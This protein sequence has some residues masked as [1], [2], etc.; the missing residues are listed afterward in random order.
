MPEFHAD[1]S[2]THGAK[3]VRLRPN[4]QV[5]VVLGNDKAVKIDQQMSVGSRGWTYPPAFGDRRFRVNRPERAAMFTGKLP[6]TKGD[7]GPWGHYELS[8]RLLDDGLIRLRSSYSLPKGEHKVSYDHILLAVPF[9]LVAGRSMSADGQRVKFSAADA[10]L[11][12]QS[13]Y[14]FPHRNIHVLE[15][16]S[17]E[18]DRHLKIGIEKGRGVFVREQRS[19]NQYGDQCAIVGIGSVER[20]IAFTLDIRRASP[21][22]LKRSGDYFEGIDFY[23][24]DQLHIPRY[25][26]CRNLVQ[27]PSFEAGLRYWRY[28]TT[29]MPPE[30]FVEPYV[31][32]PSVARSGR[33]SCRF[34]V[35]KGL[36]LRGLATFAI[37]TE[38]GKPYTFSFYAKAQ[39]PGLRLNV[40]VTTAL[41]GVFPKSKTFNIATEWQRHT[42]AVVAPNN[43]LT[44]RFHAL[45]GKQDKD[46][47]ILWVDDVQ[48]E[49]GE[50][51]EYVQKPVLLN[52]VTNRR[53]NL[54]E[55][56][57]IIAARLVVKAAP[58]AKGQ[59]H[60]KIEDFEY[61]PVWQDTVE[62][63]C[64]PTGEAD[65][66]LPLDGRLP[67]GIFYVN[68]AVV[69]ADGFA[70]HDFFRITIMDFLE[71]RH[72]HHTICG[73]GF[74]PGPDQQRHLQRL[75][76]IGMG[77]AYDRPRS[78]AWYDDLAAQGIEPAYTNLF[79][80]KRVGK[81]KLTDLKRVAD[82]TPEVEKAIRDH[83]R[84]LVTEYPYLKRWKLID[85]PPSTM[86][87]A[88]LVKVAEIAYKAVKEVNPEALVMTHTPCNMAATAGIRDVDRFLAAGGI[89]YIDFVGINCYRNQPDNPDMDAD[90]ATFLAMLDKHGY[91]GEIN[92]CGSY[93]QNYNLPAYGLDV[94][95]GCSSDHFRTGPFSYHAGWGERM[96]AAYTARSWLI[97]YKYG[98]RVRTFIDWAYDTRY[99]LD[100]DMTPYAVSMAP[101]TLG[102]LLGNADFVEDVTFDGQIRCYLFRDEHDRPVAAMW[103]MIEAVARRKQA[104][105]VLSA[106]G[107]SAGIEVFSLMGAARAGVEGD[108]LQV[109][110]TPYPVFLRGA[111][112]TL[113]KMRDT[114]SNAKV[115]GIKP[116]IVQV[117]TK[118]V[119]KTVEV[120]FRNAL[121]R[122]VV[123]TADVIL[124]GR[125][126]FHEALK[127][128]PKAEHRFEVSIAERVRT[129]VFSDVPLK[130]AFTPKGEESIEMDAGFKVVGAKRAR[131][132]IRADGD[133]SDWEGLPVIDL[134]AVFY[135]GDVPIRLRSK[136]PER[137]AWKGPSDLSARMRLAWDR[138]RLY[139]AFTVS[140]DVFA[141]YKEKGP[142]SWKGD[143]LQL[144]FDTWCDARSKPE[145]GFDYNDYNYDICPGSDGSCVAYR[146]VA[147]EQQLAFLKPNQI[148]RAVECACK[149]E[150]GRT[151][152]EVAFPKRQLQPLRLEP[153]AAFGFAAYIPDHDNDYLKRGLTLTLVPQTSPYMRPHLW[154]VLVLVE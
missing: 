64:K 99:L 138:D 51:T 123:G 39:Q 102:V 56:G 44:V 49:K 60:I 78:K 101:N 25:G 87:V 16:F 30:K 139:L 106:S 35:E 5:I 20:E 114:L 150:G 29:W 43:A 4:G 70:D 73:S 119:G 11:T 27:N 86:D 127:L 135:E 122:P 104:P 75:R 33:Q 148:E 144:Y 83:C 38:A 97:G 112:G 61:A 18:P 103:P 54:F 151:I 153:G 79:P 121:S 149:R 48:L 98:R 15:L 140:D 24:S 22:A 88:I 125:K 107:A 59:V 62:F 116:Q 76:R 94:H 37:P 13:K 128:G 89:K 131:K 141:C 111:A 67:R 42:Y 52:L 50:P 120:I 26:L 57:E 6:V 36:R 55:P 110:L 109:T 41:W 133:L 9:G 92:L 132:T 115:T 8:V 68:A 100:I 142:A 17:D 93:H 136:H 117:L 71:N 23:K 45:Y 34:Y 146:R 143:C 145:R 28:S 81:L 96:C 72:R 126:V 21:A 147:P 12:E 14:I 58:G 137:I 108:R 154:P 65:A 91:D 10:P 80:R 134:P 1:G 2:I 124:N 130:A 32:D 7:D 69:M 118:N 129:D 77:S 63:V 47:G 66:A 95:R 74:G 31:A 84:G 53:D 19:K 3:S 82:L 90:L 40:G 152:Y 105:P 113:A 46:Y 85:E